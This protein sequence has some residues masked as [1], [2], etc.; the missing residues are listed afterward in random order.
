MFLTFDVSLIILV[1]RLKKKG[2]VMLL[3]IFLLIVGIIGRFLPHAPNFTPV[4]AVALFGGL[5]LPRRY[6]LIVTILLLAVSDLIIGWH[7]TMPFTWSC[8]AL[9]ALGGTLLREHKSFPMILGASMTVALFFFVVTN[10]GVWVVGGLY[11]QTAEGLAQCFAMALPFFRTTLF[12]TVLYMTLFFS[13]NELAAATAKN[14]R[15][16]FLIR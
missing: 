9:I 16:A 5:Y 4:I 2:E 7:N 12:S 14:S 8:L 6:S 11:P 13:V 3:I 15:F 10:F 1:P